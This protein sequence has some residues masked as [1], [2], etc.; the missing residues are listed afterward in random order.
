MPTIA[1]KAGVAVGVVYRSWPSKEA[2]ADAGIRV[3]ESIRG[4]PLGPV[5]GSPDPCRRCSG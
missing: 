2:I 1:R 3:K 5:S 4:K